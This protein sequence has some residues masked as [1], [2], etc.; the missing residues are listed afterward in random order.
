MNGCSVQGADGDQ[1]IR[2]WGGFSERRS[3]DKCY[4]QE[5][6]AM[7]LSI[8]LGVFGVDQWYAHHWYWLYSK[9]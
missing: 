9:R 8:F 7:L 4:R 3:D 6:T 5:R 2:R 1:L